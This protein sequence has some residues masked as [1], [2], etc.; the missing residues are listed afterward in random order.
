MSE[1]LRKV[2]QVIALVLVMFSVTRILA[3][4]TVGETETAP[5]RLASISDMGARPQI[6]IRADGSMIILW[7]QR[8][9]EP[10]GNPA[11]Y[12][13][14]SQRWQA[15]SV[16]PLPPGAERRYPVAIAAGEKVHIAYSQ[17]TTQTQRIWHYVLGDEVMEESW[18]PPP[19]RQ[20][21]FTVDTTGRLHYVWA[22]DEALH[23]INNAQSLTV[24]I[25]ID[26]AESIGDLSLDADGGGRAHLVW[27]GT[28]TIE[29]KSH[30]Y[31]A[32]LVTDTIPVT[33]AQ[34]GYDPQLTVEASGI[35]HLCWRN[36]DGLHYASSRDWNRATL[37]D[38]RVSTLDTYSLAVGPGQE[39]HLIWTAE[40]TLWYAHSVDWEAS[41]RQI[42]SHAPKELDAIADER[43]SPH[44]TWAAETD[45][46]WD[47]LY[48]RIMPVQPQITVR[49]PRGGEFVT[50]NTWAKAETNVNTEDILRV[51]FYL[52]VDDPFDQ[53]P[54]CLNHPLRE[55]GIDTNGQDGWTVPLPT[56]NLKA[57]EKYRVV[58]VATDARGNTLRAVGGW[59]RAQPPQGPCTTLR[60]PTEPV[61]G[62][63][64]VEALTYRENTA[65]ER[66]ELYLIPASEITK[67]RLPLPDTSH[68]VGSYPYPHQQTPSPQATWRLSY[69]SRLFPDGRYTATAIAVDASGRRAYLWP[70]EPFVIDNVMAPNL[71]ITWPKS[72]MVV[73]GDTLRV[74]AT[75]DDV[76]GT[77]E[78]VSFY[79]EQNYS[80]ASTYG[81]KDP[82]KHKRLFWLGQDTDG[83]DG[84]GLQL[85]V[86]PCW[87]GERCR[88]WAIALDERGLQESAYSAGTF[89]LLG[90]E[91]PY[92][93]IL[94][95][96]PHHPLRG[97]VTIRAAIRGATGSVRDV[98]AY[99][100]P[101]NGAL[102]LLGPLMKKGSYFVHEWD[103]RQVL[104]GP[105][106]L[107]VI[108]RNEEGH[109]FSA[110]GEKF[111]VDNG[112]P[113]YQFVEP[114]SGQA[115]SGTIRVE[116]QSTTESASLESISLYYRDEAGQLYPVDEGHDI[117]TRWQTTWNTRTALDGTYHLVALLTDAE[118]NTRRLEQEAVVRNAT[119]CV[120]FVSF[121]TQSAWQGSHLVQWQIHHPLG[122]PTSVSLEYSA[123]DGRSWTEIASGI[124]ARN[125]YLWDT[126][127]Y[128]D[129]RQGRLRLSV[130]DSLHYN[131]AISGPF[132]LN[133]V[134]EAPEVRLLAPRPGTMNKE[135]TQIA[136][137][138]WDPDADPIRVTLAYRCG[139]DDWTP[140]AS[141]LSNSG[142]FTWDT[143][144]LP[145]EYNY[146][147]KIT[148]TDPSG[149]TAT[150]VVEGLELVDNVAPSVHL[151]WPSRRTCLEDKTTILW[152]ARDADGDRLAIDIY[153]SDNAGQSWIPLAEGV[154]NTGFY[155]W[156]VSYLPAG[157]QYRV[158]VVARDQYSQS[159][160][161]SDDVLTIGR[162]P[163]P[164][165]TLLAPA[166]AQTI[167]GIQPVRWTAFDP[168]G[169]PLQVSITIQH[170]GN[171]H[172]ETLGTSSFS[173]GLLLWNTT[174]FRN[175]TYDLR[176]V[177]TNGRYSAS[178]KLTHPVSV[179]NE[180]NC[181]PYVRLV[182]PQ[183]GEV[184]SG[185]REVLWEAWDSDGDP[186]TATLSTRA[187]GQ[188]NWD[189]LAVVDGQAGHYVWDTR[190]MQPEDSYMLRIL[191]RD[192]AHSA[193]DATSSPIQLTNHNSHPPHIHL[194]LPNE[195]ARL[196]QSNLIA[197]IAED[198]DA[199]PLTVDLAIKGREDRE[200]QTLATGLYNGGEY[201]LD[202]P[203]RS[204]MPYQVRAIASD[205]TY[206]S[207][208]ISRPFT[209]SIATKQLPNLTLE[210][211]ADKDVWS[212][213]EEIRWQATDPSRQNLTMRIEI[214]R[215]GG[216]TWDILERRWQNTGVYTWDTTAHA[217]GPFLL[218]LT[219]DNG[220]FQS[221]R[222][223]H[224]FLLK[225]P[226]GTPPT[227]SLL[228]PQGG[229]TWS[230]IQE[231]QWL[232]RDADGDEL[233]VDLAYRITG[234]SAWQ[235]IAQSV[236]NTGRYV[237]DTT[238][239]PNCDSTE[240]RIAVSD[241]Q[242][243]GRDETNTPFA[244]NNPH[245][246][247]IQ[248]IAPQGGE[249]WWGRQ[250]VKW[251]TV[252]ETRMTHVNVQLSTDAENRWTLLASDLS[253]T[254]SYLWDTTTVP[255]RS[256]TWIRVTADEYAQQAIDT[257][258]E[259]VIVRNEASSPLLP[260]YLK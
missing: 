111:M 29:N 206:A 146:A 117:Q 91:Q 80:L 122:T 121:A 67:T 44:L 76:D 42:S 257:L 183:G 244:V 119:P 34:E 28:N 230:G 102:T 23:Y 169:L 16:I 2:S 77:V 158:K 94:D 39:A 60:V 166:A 189:P 90:G 175:G 21:A 180:E 71:E 10:E 157:A 48:Q 215:D 163:Q 193:R 210:M 3:Q 226:G 20:S 11:L 155:E 197:W 135:Q 1:S 7:V 145:T 160:A 126:T 259:P 240:I 106:N 199:D 190:E 174:N 19:H 61:R 110:A 72:G 243:L 191:V 198:P 143:S 49:Y 108:G 246:P 188:S 30:I 173:D 171:E 63:S 68:Y 187:V 25:S 140:I 233:H 15:T 212:G 82:P 79:L 116:I 17:V 231:I 255:D 170:E 176:A 207:E 53:S 234:D 55:L 58:A 38:D 65:F 89:V 45:T 47:I 209:R 235:A 223:S 225:N 36:E 130:S 125:S 104:D 46:G 202:F 147:L 236:P 179:S 95:P 252:H 165:I 100:Q 62:Q 31:Y 241:G 132:V 217:N 113:S 83:T 105:Y 137:H 88:I 248:L 123:D 54:Q 216:G 227:V 22:Q 101:Q 96:V 238:D 168:E 184:W 5:V 153:Y 185:K 249:E 41:R 192:T 75:A 232:A 13:A 211:P 196:P 51:E 148:A 194:L 134:N 92:V 152:T 222:I 186:I 195:A 149:S 24:T 32:P 229:E 161:A 256:A 66:L 35:A 247:W 214:S 159:S 97:T 52:Q 6:V 74:S 250:E 78:R 242:F 93:R 154:S 57:V 112:P 203:L 18:Q 14:Q 86:D 131:E 73:T 81:E 40:E 85:P 204:E 251:V 70:T 237:C 205:S 69:D 103:T 127:L 221:T 156:Q 151:L 133:N 164:R 219:A 141:D 162:N 109:P 181:P 239:L 118:G 50:D 26:P 33:V 218:R 260:F 4:A 258:L 107:L 27:R 64:Y 98:Q 136:W 56:A 114:T 213:R 167:S 120:S 245:T 99:L 84:W 220:Y 59:F 208:A 144:Q 200:W 115:I 182:S 142:K 224:P 124:Q 9:K 254:G 201:I 43:G 37:I 128:P 228:S 172:W 139:D 87:R 129:S 8:E 138:A 253:P 150:Q 177:A 178:D 12:T